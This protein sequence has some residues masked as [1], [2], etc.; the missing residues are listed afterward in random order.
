[1]AYQNINQ[2]N[3]RKWYLKPVNEITDLCLASDERNYN[4]EV[5]F[6]PYL[7]A[8]T[9]GEKLPVY[10]DLNDSNCNQLLT[11]D[12]GEY[13]SGNTLVS[14]NYYT[15]L[16]DL[17]CTTASTI[18]D[19]GLTG[20]DNGLV[21]Q[22]TGKT[23]HYTNGFFPNDRKFDRL[24]FD[25]R[26]KF[27]QVTGNTRSNLQ[28]SGLSA[29]TLYEIVTVTGTTTG[30]YEQLYGGFYQGFYKL[31][32][33]DYDILPERMHQG[34]TAEFL[35]KPRLNNE[36]LPG[37]GFTTLNQYYPDNKNIFFYMGTR[38]E[39]K[40]YHFASGHPKSDS[41]Y[42]R[43]TSALTDCQTCLCTSADTT[44]I[45]LCN[46]DQ[47]EI[48]FNCTTIYPLSGFTIGP[49]E[50]THSGGTLCGC[51]H[52][53]IPDEDANPLFNSMS[54][55]LAVKFSGDPSNP[56]I[57]VRTLV[58]TGGCEVTGAC[59][60]SGIT[61]VTGY[62]VHEYCSTKGIWD[63][64]S[65][66]TFNTQEHWAQID[67][68][69]KR[70]SWFDTCDLEYLGGLGLITDVVYPPGIE[71]Y[72]I[73]LIQPPIT[74]SGIT[75]PTQNVYQLNE[76]WLETGKYRKGQLIISVN[77][78]RFFVV[79]DVEEII[80]RALD[81]PRQRQVGVPFNMSWGGGT[82]GLHENLTFTACPVTITG[83]TYQ[84]DP[85]CFPNY[86]LSGTS[87]SG[88][89]TN[90]LLE[91]Y[92]AGTFEGGISQ[93]RFYIEPLSQ[94]E[95]R[96]NFKL[97][98]SQ[99]SMYDPFCPSCAI[100]PDDFEYDEYCADPT[101]TPTTSTTPT[102]TPTTTATPTTTP[103]PTVTTNLTPTPTPNPT[104]TPTNTPTISVT[105]SFTPTPSPTRA[106]GPNTVFMGFDIL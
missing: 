28:F 71:A 102:N 88:L 8:E 87:L 36:Y 66:T 56:K 37:P 68:T 4:E 32:G 55:A 9:Y 96:H 97:L 60:T 65:G 58:M 5:V 40:F 85:E 17:D 93:F 90:I 29:E 74:H 24:H 6:S 103:T 50:C 98:K 14:L 45:T 1:M 101:P 69:W 44:D 13:N 51:N 12:Y 35:V 19:V 89:T 54:N 33:Y 82:Q 16:A 25:R 34:W 47:I 42:T 43:V 18:C 26:M 59:E 11:L 94:P 3:F 52:E 73:P 95:I 31:Y 63:N 53:I 80:P 10:L 62:T 106:V 15:G 49:V 91:R 48:D 75:V 2:Y 46:G 20:I 86:I 92:F 67:V 27:I 57:C 70:Y 41:G 21:D 61:Y 39:D 84:Q 77:G 105:P 99:F 83:L 72:Q 38:A 76:K 30:R 22:M 81:T 100:L 7:I 104:S 23:L 79:E 64:C 78:M